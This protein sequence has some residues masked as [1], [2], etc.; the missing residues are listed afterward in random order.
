MLRAVIT[1][2]A[3]Q[4][5]SYLAE[6][7]LDRGYEVFG[8]T[9]RHGVRPNEENL[10]LLEGLENLHI[11]YG[12]ITDATFITRLLHD[13]KPHEYYNLAALSHV[14]QSFKEPVATFNTNATAVVTALEGIRT[15]SPATRFY[16]A[17]TSELFGLTPCSEDGHTEATPF[18]PRSPY[19]VAKAAAFWATVNA[20]EAWGLH[21][22]N[23]ILFNHSSPRRGPDFAS[24]KITLGLAKVKLGLA[25]TV[26]MGDLSAF[27]DEGLSADYMDAAWRMLQQDKPDDYV[28]GTGTG[29][30]IEQM[31]RHVCA[32]AGLEFDEVYEA[33]P[34]FLRPSEVPFL[35]ANAS[36]AHRVLD[37]KPSHDWRA[38]LDL[39]FDADLAALES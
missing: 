26:R 28:V 37:W 6:L 3:G 32:R 19:G 21:A 24:R 39:M 2:V 14:G 15:F 8:V 5:G 16:Q 30:T 27:R 29:A 22:S 33:D 10:H 13:V 1:G 25:K 38:V 17:S 31:F 11:R 35:K 9:R 4:D 7:L 20:R 36:K 34:R 23:G 18:H 12:D